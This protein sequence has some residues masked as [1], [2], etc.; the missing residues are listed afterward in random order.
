MQT[1][2]KRPYPQGTLPFFTHVYVAPVSASITT[3]TTFQL[4]IA[5]LDVT[6]NGDLGIFNNT[7]KARITGAIPVGTEYFI[8]QH[9]GF[10]PDGEAIVKNSPTIIHDLTAVKYL[11]CGHIPNVLKKDEVIVTAPAT[12]I[13]QTF[14][15]K[16]TDIT[17][18][19][20]PHNFFTL[21]FESKTGTETITEIRDELLADYTRQ[22]NNVVFGYPSELLPYF[23]VTASGTTGILI[24][25]KYPE[26]T[27]ITQLRNN[28]YSNATLNVNGV[29]NSVAWVAGSGLGFQT[30]SHEELGHISADFNTFVT[31]SRYE[32]SGQIDRFAKETCTYD[33]I[34]IDNHRREILSGGSQERYNRE[35]MN[36]L[37]AVENTVAG[38]SGSLIYTALK[39]AFGL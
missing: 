36:V 34:Q 37:V 17:M 24:E 7:T 6:T 20:E 9:R 3:A 33:Y 26:T 35:R 31:D 22:L 5:G 12:E 14:D 10:S 39:T 19:S 32:I 4:F 25:S 16:V 2:R 29:G 13:G 27:F 8:S 38:T 28:L 1:T 18:H 23:T 15:L 21:S 11:A 30:Q